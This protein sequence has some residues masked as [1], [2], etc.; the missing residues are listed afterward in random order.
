M[1]DIMYDAFRSDDIL[2]AADRLIEFSEIAYKEKNRAAIIKRF[3]EELDTYALINF[4][5]DF[6]DKKYVVYNSCQSPCYYIY[7]HLKRLPPVKAIN[8]IKLL[9]ERIKQTYTAAIG[10]RI[11]EEEIHMIMKHLDQEFNFSNLVFGTE[12]ALFL[13]FNNSHISF[14][15]EYGMADC[16]HIQRHTFFLY[17]MSA[18]SMVE[19]PFPE[20][21]L[22]HEIGHALHAKLTGDIDKMPPRVIDFLKLSFPTIEML[23]V[24]SQREIFADVIAMGMMHG[25]SLSKYD[26]FTVIDADVKEC[27]KTM[28]SRLTDRIE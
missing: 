21:V 28:V 15:S 9:A 4:A 26:P 7:A 13:L 8:E 6:S 5:F 1:Y 25:S 20:Y 14:N 27:F 23:P 2:I 11:T 19:A 3:Y 12:K 22:L 18:N 10:P 16:G 24:E 17:S